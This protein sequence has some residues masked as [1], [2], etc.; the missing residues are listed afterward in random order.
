MCDGTELGDGVP[1]AANHA[2]PK[3]YAGNTRNNA[4]KNAANTPGWAPP[5]RSGTP[6]KSGK[7]GDGS[8]RHP[9]DGVADRK[10]VV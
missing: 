10:S 3:K 1:L 2:A 4:A 8:G 7:Q 5:A 6:E 9:L